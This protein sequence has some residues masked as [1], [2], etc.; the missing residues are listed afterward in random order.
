MVN[1]SEECMGVYC[2][3]AF[4]LFIWIFK[5][6]WDKDGILVWSL[7]SHLAF[8]KKKK[9]TLNLFK[10]LYIYPSNISLCIHCI[11]QTNLY[12]NNIFLSLLQIV[13]NF[14]PLLLYTACFLRNIVFPTLACGIPGFP[15]KRVTFNH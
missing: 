15:F 11:I 14:F 10:D 2:I 6:N 13:H 3:L 1:L 9:I 8:S 4:F 7:V 5:I 12:F